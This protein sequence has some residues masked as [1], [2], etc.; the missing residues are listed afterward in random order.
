[1]RGNLNTRR[2]N[3]VNTDQI[4]WSGQITKISSSGKNTK[5]IRPLSYQPS[6]KFICPI[7][8]EKSKCEYTF[9]SKCIDISK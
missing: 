6:L 9:K 7:T 8:N 1:M 4:N 5:T 3:N 2:E